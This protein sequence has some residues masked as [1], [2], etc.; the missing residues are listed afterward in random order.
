MEGIWFYKSIDFT[1]I[2]YN[3]LD[4]PVGPDSERDPS[5]KW[6]T[7][8]TVIVPRKLSPAAAKRYL[9]KQLGD[10]LIEQTIRITTYRQLY[11]IPAKVFLQHASRVMTGSDAEQETATLEE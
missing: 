8:S 10:R 1:E 5:R 9:R 11:R 2:G 7:E 4:A 6:F 3:V